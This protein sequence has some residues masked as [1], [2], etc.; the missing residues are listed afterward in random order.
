[1]KYVS[2]KEN[3]SGVDSVTAFGFNSVIAFFYDIFQYNVLYIIQ[4]SK[5]VG[6]ESFSK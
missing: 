2:V 1:M 3:E 5:A 6:T 4:S